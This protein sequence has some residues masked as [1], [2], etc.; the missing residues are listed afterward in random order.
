MSRAITAALVLGLTLAGCSKPAAEKELP[1]APDPIRVVDDPDPAVTQP[2]APTAAGSGS[3]EF[4]CAAAAATEPDLK[5]LEQSKR[6]DDAGREVDVDTFDGTG[7][8]VF[9][10]PALYVERHSRDGASVGVG[11]YVRADAAAVRQK[12]GER[13]PQAKATADG[14]VGEGLRHPIMLQDAEQ[15]LLFIQCV[16]P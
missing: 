15:G 9:G 16:A 11:T 13:F 5:R 6:P 1:F 7:L 2:V 3:S 14:F 10:F 8:A 4:E 12:I